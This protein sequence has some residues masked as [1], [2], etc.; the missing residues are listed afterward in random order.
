M[1]QNLENLPTSNPAEF[2][3]FRCPRC[4]STLLKKGRKVW[5]SFIGGRNEKSCDFGISEPAFVSTKNENYKISRRAI[6]EISQ[7]L[8]GV[9]YL[10]QGR[11][12]NIG[13]DCVGLLV[14]IG[15]RCDYPYLRDLESYAR[16]PSASKLLETLE[17]NLFEIPLT[18]VRIGDFYLM[19]MGGIKPRHVAVKVSDET[20]YITGI[21][22]MLIHALS[23]GGINAVVK[24]PV[25]VWRSQF[26]KGFR[27]HGLTE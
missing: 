26:V 5:C 15:K 12:V 6:C 16:V 4:G 8:I 13:I 1:S 17:A 21:E 23:N 25:S 9:P 22:P 18:E 19:K 14:E 24:Q 11:D 7:S 3:E 10:H 2:S 20:D 27:A